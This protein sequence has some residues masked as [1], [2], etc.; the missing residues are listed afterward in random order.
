MLADIVDGN[1]RLEAEV[2][3]ALTDDQRAKLQ[4]RRE[5]LKPY[6]DYG[7]YFR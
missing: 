7:R 2:M 4:E 5:R 3:A 6:V 1:R